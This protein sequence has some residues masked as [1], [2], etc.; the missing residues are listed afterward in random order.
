MKDRK[1][2]FTGE[3]LDAMAQ[4]Y[5]KL[6]VYYY[7]GR[8]IEISDAI[9]GDPALEYWNEIDYV[10]DIGDFLRNILDDEAMDFAHLTLN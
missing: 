3:K 8:M 9:S 6:C 10:S 7:G 4:F 5:A 1:F 2:L